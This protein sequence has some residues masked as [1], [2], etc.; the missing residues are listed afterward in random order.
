MLLLLL[1]GERRQT[2]WQYGLLAKTTWTWAR[3][4]DKHLL[5]TRGQVHSLLL[6]L[7]KHVLVQQLIWANLAR[8]LHHVVR[9]RHADW[10][11]HSLVWIHWP[12]LDVCTRL[13][14]LLLLLSL[15]SLPLLLHLLLFSLLPLLFQ[16]LLNLVDLLGQQVI[17]LGS[18]I[19]HLVHITLDLFRIGDQIVHALVEHRL[20]IRRGKDRLHELMH[21]V[22][23]QVRC[24]RVVPVL[25]ALH[26]SRNHLICG[27]V[28]CTTGT[29]SSWLLLLA[30]AAILVEQHVAR[31]WN[32]VLRLI[33]LLLL[34]LSVRLL[35]LQSSGHLAYTL[36]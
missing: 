27:E 15:G 14:E 34:Q 9:S 5:L 31:Q 17:I 21:Q 12:Y 4:G 3:L 26:R 6:L 28:P 18:R 2:T 11:H 25:R 20:R 16:L 22:V 33:L 7:L 24:H 30:T 8:H 10:I 32:D 35:L 29:A 1:G 36:V 13:L 23:P 19:R